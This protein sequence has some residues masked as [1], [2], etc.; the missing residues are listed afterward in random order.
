MTLE[1]SIELFG[2]MKKGEPSLEQILNEEENKELKDLSKS[3]LIELI[4][5]KKKLI[6]Q[7]KKIQ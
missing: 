1:G 5:N 7:M 6:T 2:I 3:E 4:E